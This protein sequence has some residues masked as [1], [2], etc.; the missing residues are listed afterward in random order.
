MTII[1]GNLLN[2]HC[3]NFLPFSVLSDTGVQPGWQQQPK[4]QRQRQRPGLRNGEPQEEQP[5]PPEPESEHAGHKLLETTS[6]LIPHIIK[7]KQK[8]QSPGIH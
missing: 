7:S 6:N 2:I 3:I 8:Q 5:R 1:I 4:A